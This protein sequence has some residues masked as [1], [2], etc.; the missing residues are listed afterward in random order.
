[1]YLLGSE[2]AETRP[3]CAR[4]GCALL[5][6]S[7]TSPGP[8]HGYFDIGTP[9]AGAAVIED[10]VA[11]GA[12]IV[13]CRMSHA[14]AGAVPTDT[15]G[16]TSSEG[17]SWRWARCLEYVSVTTP[18]APGGWPTNGLEWDIRLASS[19]RRSVAR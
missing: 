14:E 2:P 3:G 16:V 19:P 18:S 1:M 12:Q 13:R 9:H 17:P 15:A 11:L 8:H 6:A 4:P 5:P 7:S 10:I